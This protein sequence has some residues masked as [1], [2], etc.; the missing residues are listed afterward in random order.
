LYEWPWVY[1]PTGIF[2][3]SNDTVFVAEFGY[4]AGPVPGQLEPPGEVKPRARVTVRDLGGDIL[5]RWG[6]GEDECAAGCF[7][8]PHCVWA[9]SRGDLYVGEV[10][11]AAGQRGRLIPVGCHALQ[12]FVRVP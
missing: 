4:R 7:F 10:I 2:I 6:E 5:A 12:K 1:R 8:A 9:D 3:D 11:S